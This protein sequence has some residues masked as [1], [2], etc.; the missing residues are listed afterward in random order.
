MVGVAPIDYDINKSDYS[1]CGW[2]MYCYNSHLYSGPPYNY[3]N[4]PIS[5]SAV[6]DE[7]IIVMNM[8]K[9]SLKFIINNEDKGDAYTNIPIEKPVVP[10]VIIHS[11]NDSVEIKKC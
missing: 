6:K 10:A 8:N 4:K 5:L 1:N 9:R 3:S 7:V 2:Y 11:I